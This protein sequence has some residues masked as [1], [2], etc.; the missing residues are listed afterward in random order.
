MRGSLT[1]ARYIQLNI[2]KVIT[3]TQLKDIASEYCTDI[4]ED[5]YNSFIEFAD[6]SELGIDL[7]GNVYTNR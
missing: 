5:G 6:G 4:S 2:A 3:Y 1:V 7:C